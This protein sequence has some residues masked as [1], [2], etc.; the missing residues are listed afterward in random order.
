MSLT[1]RKLTLIILIFALSLFG[2][3]VEPTTPT[4]LRIFDNSILNA[5]PPPYVCTLSV[6]STDPE[7]DNIY[8]EIQWDTDQSLSSPSSTTIGPYASGETVTTTIL[9][10]STPAEVETLFYWKARA[11]DDVPIN[12]SSWSKTRSFTMDMEVS[13]VYWYQVAGDQF[14]SCTENNLI[15]KGD[16]VV[17][18]LTVIA[19]TTTIL[20]ENWENPPYT[21]WNFPDFNSDSYIWEIGTTNR[22]ATY[23]PPNFGNFYA[24]Y[25][26]FKP[27]NTPATQER[28]DHDPL[29]IDP[30]ADSLKIYF[31]YG[32]NDRVNEAL[33][34]YVYFYYP[35]GD[36]WG[37]S[38]AY[39]WYDADNSGW[40]LVNLSDTLYP[41]ITGHE[42]PDSV[43]F[44]WIYFDNG[45]RGSAGA[46][47]SVRAFTIDTTA[48]PPATEGTLL[49]TAVV[50]S[51]LTTENPGRSHWDGVKCTKSSADDSIGVQ[52]EYKSA[53]VWDLVPE[54]DLPGNSTGFF[55]NSSDF[56]T[57]DL[58]SLNPATY[59]TLCIKALLLRGSGKA[60]SDPAL[61]MWAL[62]NTEGNITRDSSII[63]NGPG[64]KDSK[65]IRAL[66]ST[67]A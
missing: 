44:A 37:S 42:R 22:L 45:N 40:E 34:F 49:G 11:R 59:D 54:G 27:G 63:V 20:V 25:N 36:T 65:R 21:G 18:D 8:Y 28:I 3:G 38:N 58:S 39:R 55:D 35:T 23:E 43:E 6:K 47:D 2:G 5:Y 9:L 14:E 29:Y 32:F 7:V 57:V 64:R 53:G 30:D 48:G 10:G 17:L 4:L 51:D 67:F 16:S 66:R 26:D 60:S 46:I 31:E 12:W 24:Y 61:K 41:S 19:D 50:Y 33:G 62:G 1:N 52:I 15:V 13:G 56:Y